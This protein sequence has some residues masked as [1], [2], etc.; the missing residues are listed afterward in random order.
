M[1]KTERV[2][3]IYDRLRQAHILTKRG[4][5]AR[6]GVDERTIQRDLNDIRAHLSEEGQFGKEL[7]YDRK[8][9]G[10]LIR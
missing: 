7:I 4:E 8:K 6:F 2:L 10:Y 9:M 3:S 1:T 5:A